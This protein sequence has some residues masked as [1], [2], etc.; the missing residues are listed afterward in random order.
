MAAPFSWRERSSAWKSLG[1]SF[2]RFDLLVIGGGI[3]GAAIARDAALRGLHVLIVDKGDFGGG[4]SSRSSKL[5][6]GGVRYLEQYEFGLVAESTR[7]R[8][9]LWKLAPDLVK[10][11]QFLFPAY[12]DS[13]VPLWKLEAGLWLYDVL[14]LFR[15]PSL[16]KLLLKSGARKA[17]PLLK[18]DGLKGA[19]LY[20][21]A[22]T[23]DA[24]LTLA[25]VIDAR[26][27]GATAFS[28][29]KVEGV[30]WNSRVA[31]DAQAFHDV[32]LRDEL[33]GDV[34]HVHARAVVAAG[35][36]WTDELLAKLGHASP[37][38][39]LA[40]TR[41]SHIVV[42]RTHFDLHHAVVMTHPRDGRVLFG[43]PWGTHAIIGTTDIYD[44]DSPDRTTISSDEVAYLLQATSEFFPRANLATKDV[45]STWSGLR[46][47]LAP[48]AEASASAVSREHHIEWFAPG[49]LMIAGGK[50][51]THREMAEQA[52]TALA[53]HT[54]SWGHPPGNVTADP[55]P[56]RTRPLPRFAPREHEVTLTAAE[57]RHVCRTEMPL[58]LEDLLVRRTAVFYKTRDNGEA[59]LAEHKAVLKDEMGWDETRWQRET[60][61][62]ARYV[63]LNV[64]KP[65]GR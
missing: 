22:A 26:A 31:K 41:G 19:L 38:P 29:V 24:R 21:D 58:T 4:T 62:Y 14:A 53:K 48:P 54:S 60:D 55:S 52:L 18:S 59:F 3:V 9:R 34:Q 61:D 35:G 7:E 65:L 16:H 49:L 50:L 46:P 12:A 17:E 64:T 43:I 23:D 27:A 47:L 44:T 15:L 30:T 6:H 1:S 20:W 51:T 56:T 8:A 25:N 40:T 57:L 10:P 32:T 39:R 42:E 63:Q 33:T 28:R 2:A 5:V 11:L 13:R 45:V 37:R 36:P